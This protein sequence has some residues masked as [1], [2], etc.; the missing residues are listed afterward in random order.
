MTKH[1]QKHCD[2]RIIIPKYVL[3][4]PDGRDNIQEDL[5]KVIDYFKDCGNRNYQ[6]CLVGEKESTRRN[7]KT[8]IA[9]GKEF[10]HFGTQSLNEEYAFLPISVKN[11]IRRINKLVSNPDND[12]NKTTLGIHTLG[13]VAISE[14][15][16]LNDAGYGTTK[17]NSIGVFSSCTGFCIFSR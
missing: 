7:Y 8:I 4:G 14:I 10:I 9:K 3:G 15:K 11:S 2:D 5:K 1:E 6:V 17:W 12:F 16:P 13:L